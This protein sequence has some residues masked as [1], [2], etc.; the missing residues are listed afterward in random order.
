MISDILY[1]LN[2][3]IDGRGFAGRIKEFKPPVIKPKMQSYSAGGLAAEIDVPM[4]RIEKMEAEATLTAFDSDTLK[5]FGVLP[6][7]Q[8]AM[9]ARGAMVSDD[10]TKKPVIITM[11]GLLSNIDKGTWKPG[12]EMPLKLSLSLRYYKLEIDGAVIYDIDPIN[13]VM[14]IN[15]EDQL[16]T[17]RQHLAI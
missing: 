4:G 3:F 14:I 16:E 2:L 17:T 12:E 9:T 10:G 5:L 6:G 8:V 11:R 15:G 13:Y 7:R 1:D